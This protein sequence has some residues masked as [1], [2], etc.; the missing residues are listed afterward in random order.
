MI[1]QLRIFFSVVIIM[2]GACDSEKSE[3]K[4]HKYFTEEDITEKVTLKSEKYYFEELK[5]PMRIMVKGEFLI[6]GEHN[7]IDSKLPPVHIID[8]NNWKYVGSKGVIGFGPGEISDAYMLDAGDEKDVFW[9]YSAS[10]KKFS[11]FN[12]DDTLRLSKNQIKQ[13]GKFYMAI[14]MVLSSDNTLICRMA[15]D[16]NRFVEFDMDGNRL[17][18]FGDWKS[19][20]LSKNL[21]NYMMC[22]LHLS[23]LSGNLEKDIFVAAGVK[24]DRV[25]ILNRKNKEIIVING[26]VNQVPKFHLT[27]GTNGASTS[28]IMDRDEPYKYRDVFVGDKYIYGLYCGR[29][30]K[31]I[32][33]TG[34]NATEVFVFD[35]EGNILRSLSLDRSLQNLVVDEKKH[36]LYGITTDEDPGIAVFE[37]P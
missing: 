36:K 28:V 4:N 7:R 13:N 16:P 21:N 3:D 5:R 14:S 26:P 10:E 30:N 35:L 11:E 25:E 33:S 12:I 15:N 8:R 34:L 22:D 20:P 1:K 29:T 37:M 27:K 19:F 23:R 31:E 24:R 18:G 17:N 9:V 6:I 32:N 2:M